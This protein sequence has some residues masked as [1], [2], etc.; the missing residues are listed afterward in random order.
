MKTI[1]AFLILV[2]V[3]ISHAQENYKYMQI[4]EN[5]Q[6][7]TFEM[8]SKLSHYIENGY[9]HYI[10]EINGDFFDYKIIHVEYSPQGTKLH[11][12][13]K[14][15]YMMCFKNSVGL[16]LVTETKTWK[17]FFFNDKTKRV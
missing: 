17:Y 7:E 14:G 15:S 6:S 11:I 10:I 4:F 8:S 3:C 16:V 2:N 12:D 1:I 5:G 9:Y 13:S